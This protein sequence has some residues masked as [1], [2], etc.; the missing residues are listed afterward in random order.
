LDK[1]CH[2]DSEPYHCVKKVIFSPNQKD[3]A[4][5][6]AKKHPND[7]LFILAEQYGKK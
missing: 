3:M 6:T 2:S 1:K 4:L 7:Y 5:A